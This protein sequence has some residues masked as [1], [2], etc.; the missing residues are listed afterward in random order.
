MAE[1]VAALGEA[2]RHGAVRLPRG[3][4][5]TKRCGRGLEVLLV[6]LE[7]ALRVVARLAWADRARHLDP[8]AA[9]PGDLERREHAVRRLDAACSCDLELRQRRAVGAVEHHVHRPA[10]AALRDEVLLARREDLAL[11][12]PRLEALEEDPEAFRV[13]AH[14]V[15]H[16]RELELGLDHARVVERDVPADELA[17]ARKGGVVA[18]RHHV[19]HPVDADA[20]AAHPLR[21]P[22]AGT[23]D[24]LLLVDPGRAVL[25]DVARL[26]REDD[27]RLAVDRKE[28][29][30][31][32]V[33]DHEAAEVRDRAFEARVL[34]AADDHRVEPVTRRRLAHEPVTAFDLVL[35]QSGVRRF[36]QC[37][38][39]CSTPFTSAQIAWFSGVGTPCSR[40]KR[41]IPPLR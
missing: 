41:T 40:P 13:D 37:C 1:V 7:H 6:R 2:V 3:P 24:E 22:V 28:H 20:P 11:H 36:L 19:V 10:A 29:V 14:A 30:G 31:V 4:A 18:H 26:A 8:V 32:A 17:R 25:A 27:R 21:E 9:G 38:H 33:H 23:V 12:P 5:G 15:A 16:G 34:V 35:G 39:D